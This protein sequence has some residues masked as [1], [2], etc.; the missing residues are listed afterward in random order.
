METVELTLRL[1][2]EEVELATRYAQEHGM[3]LADLIGRYLRHLRAVQCL[4]IH[5]EVE[6]ISGLIPTA[7]H[8]NAAVD[9]ST[10]RRRR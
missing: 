9:A 5:P 7:A 4:P 6:K 3:T 10:W 1:P 8:S 2:Q